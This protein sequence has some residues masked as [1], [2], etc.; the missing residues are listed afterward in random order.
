MSHFW[1]TSTLY[2][3]A[4]CDTDLRPAC[5]I[6]GRLT[7]AEIWLQ[8][9]TE[10]KCRCGGEIKTQSDIFL[11]TQTHTGFNRKPKETSQEF[12]FDF[13]V[14]CSSQWSK[15]VRKQINE[16]STV[17]ADGC[18]VQMQG[19]LRFVWRGCRCLEGMIGCRYGSYIYTQSYIYIDRKLHLHSIVWYGMEV[20]FTP[21][22]TSTLIRSYI[23][24]QLYGM[25][26]KLHLHP[27][28]HLH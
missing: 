20:T 9:Q 24:T 26:W 18:C 1:K 22:P 4:I 28:L 14:C 5:H 25:V 13:H 8:D 27:V 19:K 15:S 16:F 10:G 6:F 21:N 23:C 12:D 17:S 11:Q 2:L 3:F 7:G